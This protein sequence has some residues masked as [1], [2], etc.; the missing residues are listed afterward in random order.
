MKH[1][2]Y[3]GSAVLSRHPAAIQQLTKNSL[4]KKK[5]ECIERFG[6]H[7]SAGDNIISIDAMGSLAMKTLW[8]RKAN[9]KFV[10][11]MLL[12]NAGRPT[13]LHF[14]VRSLVP[15]ASTTQH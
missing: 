10:L 5:K 13:V 14:V 6:R 15:V 11:I 7:I 12:I 4:M 1:G 2:G 3:I 8:E 9:T